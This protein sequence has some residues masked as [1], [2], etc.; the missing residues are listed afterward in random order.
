MQVI[1]LLRACQQ[2]R[3]FDKSCFHNGGHQSSQHWGQ[4]V[5][6]KVNLGSEETQALQCFSITGS[7][8]RGKRLGA[9]RA[10]ELNSSH[11]QTRKQGWRVG[12]REG[13]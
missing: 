6:V 5:K 4:K 2:L 9:S 8:G 12:V 3:P 1:G 11:T 7:K 10:D 13:R